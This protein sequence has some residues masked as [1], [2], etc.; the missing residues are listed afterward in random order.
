MKKNSGFT[1]IEF[2][3]VVA[4]IGILAAIAVPQ[5]TAYKRRQSEKILMSSAEQRDKVLRETSSE[6]EWRYIISP[7]GVCYEIGV[8]KYDKQISA[9]SQI[10]CRRIIGGVDR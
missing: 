7:T 8:W 10:D 9:G 1:L 6:F 4:I 2:L 5:F 3:V